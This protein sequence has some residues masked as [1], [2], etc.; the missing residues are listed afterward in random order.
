MRKKKELLSDEEF[1][2]LD[3]FLQNEFNHKIYR[4]LT[5]QDYKFNDEYALYFFQILY[6]NIAFV[7]DNK[8]KPLYVIKQ[9]KNSVPDEWDLQYLCKKLILHFEKAK[10]EKINICCREIQK[11]TDEYNEKIYSQMYKREREKKVSV[12]NEILAEIESLPDNE[13]RLKH[14]KNMLIEYERNC[15]QLT[16]ILD[17]SDEGSYYS[18]LIKEIVRLEKLVNLEK[19]SQESKTNEN[20]LIPPKEREGMN[21]E[22]AFLFFKYLSEN[23]Q[24]TK[25]QAKKNKA[26]E[27]LTG[28]KVGQ[29]N[30]LPSWFEKEKAKTEE[31]LELDEKFF[32]DM[33]EVRNLFNLLGLTDLAKMIDRDLG[34]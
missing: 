28:Y 22:R 20:Q 9:L 27:L 15:D 26:I 25:N 17:V 6:S 33:G 5:S 12:H 11:I 2:E 21:I 16:H 14:L 1:A 8:H 3:S 34:S 18:Q 31:N 19:E 24:A 10:D 32:K 4:E 13:T 30:K 29:L 7:K 23:P